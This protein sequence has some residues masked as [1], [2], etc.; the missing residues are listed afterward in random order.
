[1]NQQISNLSSLEAYNLLNEENAV[2]LDVRASYLQDFKRFDVP[3]SL[4]IAFEELT[5]RAA[6]L[7]K[8]VFYICA[9][10][11]GIFSQN[12]AQILIDAGFEKAGNLA[13]GLVDWERA[14]LPVTTDIHERLSGSCMCQLKPR[15]KKS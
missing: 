4:Q 1:M 13:G 15:E 5:E 3:R 6:G 14:G 12:A 7:P 9:D 8:E 11:A 2:L 10:S